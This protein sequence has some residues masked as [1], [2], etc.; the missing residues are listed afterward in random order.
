MSTKR[1]FNYGIVVVALICLC[2]FMPNYA[3]Y[4]VSAFGSSLSEQLSLSTSQFSSIATAPLIPG[5]FLSLIAGLLVDKF[6]ERRIIGTTI[7]ISAVAI[8]MRVFSTSYLSM[9]IC[10]IFIGFCATFLNSNSA[11]VMGQWFPPEKASVTMGFFLAFSNAGIALGTG[12]ASFY[13]SMRAAFIGAAVIAVISAVCWILFMKD[14]NTVIAADNVKVER[15]SIIEGLKVCLKNKYIWIAAICQLLSVGCVTALSNFMP[16]ALVSRGLSQ[17]SASVVTMAFTLGALLSCFVSPAIIEKVGKYKLMFI[18]YALVAA[19]GIFFF[20]RLTTNTVIL[21]ILLF[22]AGF[23]SNGFS[24][25]VMS[26]PVRLEG[27][28]TKY[29]GTAGGM[30][31]TIQLGGSVVLPTYVI[32]PIA[33]DNYVLMFSMFGAMMLLFCVFSLFLPIKNSK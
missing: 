30:L 21:F 25:I 14:K 29:G 16:S 10:M 4:Q 1:K 18:I 31:A 28:G 3:Q 7:I 23:G 9:Y 8:I 12:T 19:A 17:S 5:I 20:W 33:G 22:V 26:L 2:V 13:T 6:G 11:K 27:V 32:A 15:V 24:P